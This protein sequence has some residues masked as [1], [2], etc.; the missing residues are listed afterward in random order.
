MTRIYYNSPQ[1]AGKIGIADTNPPRG[2]VP[3]RCPGVQQRT[4]AWVCAKLV[5][6]PHKWLHK[7]GVI[8]SNTASFMCLGFTRIKEI[9]RLSDTNYL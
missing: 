6:S 1:E 4:F 9:R 5:F 2:G 8:E 3:N 7:F